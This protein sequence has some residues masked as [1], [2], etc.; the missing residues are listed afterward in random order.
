MEEIVKQYT[1]AVIINRTGEIQQGEID[2][3]LQSKP[4][5]KLEIN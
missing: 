2:V 3:W 5:A 1:A 4:T